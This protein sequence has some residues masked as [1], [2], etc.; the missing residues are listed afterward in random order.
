M[1]RMIGIMVTSS[2]KVWSMNLV[3]QHSRN[4]TNAQDTTVLLNIWYVHTT[5]HCTI[6][7]SVLTSSRAI[8]RDP[9]IYSEPEAFLPERHLD[10][11]GH[12]A[13][14]TP[15]TRGLGHV[16]FGMGRRYLYAFLCRKNQFLSSDSVCVG[17]DYADQVMFIVIARILWAFNIEKAIGEDGYPITPSCTDMIDEGLTV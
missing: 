9:S 13:E 17:K 2:Q 7:I 11:S 8:N 16:S 12:L 15:N 3:M 1:A 14:A 10:S 4:L 6:P 5:D